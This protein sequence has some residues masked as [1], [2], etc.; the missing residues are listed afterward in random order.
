MVSIVKDNDTLR[1][2]FSGRIDTVAA[3]EMDC[4]INRKVLTSAMP[5]VFDMKDV[6]YVSSAFLRICISAAKTLG[7][8]RFRIVHVNPAILKVFKISGFDKLM[9]IE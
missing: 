7:S 6:A 2:V 9:V 1:C 8:E 3:T 4:E 5:V